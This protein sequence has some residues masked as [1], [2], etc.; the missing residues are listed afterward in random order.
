MYRLKSLLKN[1]NHIMKG[2][3]KKAY[4]RGYVV[5]TGLVMTIL[6]LGVNGFHHPTQDVQYQIAA[7]SEETGDEEEELTINEEPVI[8]NSEAALS[9]EAVREITAAPI[10]SISSLTIDSN[11]LF[12]TFPSERKLIE[13]HS[14]L[15]EKDYTSLARIVEAEATGED[16][17]GKILVANVVLNRVSSSRFPDTIYDV[18][19]QSENGRYQFS[20]LW[21]GRYYTVNVSE[22]TY[23]AVDLALSGEDYSEG[24]LFFVARALASDEAVNWFD[25]HLKKVM[26]YGVHEFYT[27][28][29]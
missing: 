22:S 14:L 27:Y 6:M 26:E 8:E 9:H 24:A 13:S 5:S 20:P 28:D 10:V 2:I 3:S 23:E 17:I 1:T 21:D 12:V 19:H 25:L 7:M 11:D 18:I 29:D 4:T 15:T 16:L